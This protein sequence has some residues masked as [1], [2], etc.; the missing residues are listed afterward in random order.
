MEDKPDHTCCVLGECM[1]C[2]WRKCVTCTV[3]VRV[4]FVNTL[5]LQKAR[6]EIYL[7]VNL[8][9]IVPDPVM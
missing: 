9:D 1:E 3:L 7:I 5:K 8:I 6:S 4:V 2:A